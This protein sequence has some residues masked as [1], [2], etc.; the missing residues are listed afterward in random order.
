MY[1]TML[2]HLKHILSTHPDLPT[3]VGW[4]QTC[5]SGQFVTFNPAFPHASFYQHYLMFPSITL[6]LVIISLKG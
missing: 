1:I 3:G 4:K 5:E 6:I 2:I